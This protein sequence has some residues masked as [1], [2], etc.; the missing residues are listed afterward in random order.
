M[1]R[2]TVNEYLCYAEDFFKQHGF[3]LPDW[4]Y[5]SQEEWQEKGEEC[6]EIRECMLGWDITDFGSGDFMKVGLTLFTIRNGI[7]NSPDYPKTYAEKIMIAREKQVTPIHFHWHKMEDIINRG[8]ASL[9][10]QLW[11]TTP[12]EKLSGEDFFVSMDGVKR[13]I[14]SGEIIYIE[15]GNSITLEPYVYHQFWGEGGTALIGEV[16]MVNDDANDNRFLEARPRYLEIEEDVPAR[17]LLCNEY[18]GSPQTDN[19]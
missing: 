17:F 13:K 10:I 15:P 19:I 5:W 14:K 11:E 9:A 8:G 18:P 16:S 3:K 6:K 1:K 12:D 4:A 2:S 7:V